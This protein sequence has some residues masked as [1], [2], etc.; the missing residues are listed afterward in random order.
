MG[1]LRFT[2]LARF[3]RLRLWKAVHAQEVFFIGFFCVALTS[4]WFLSTD[5]YFVIV[6]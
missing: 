2:L 5:S 4:V 6:K 3:N 1:Y